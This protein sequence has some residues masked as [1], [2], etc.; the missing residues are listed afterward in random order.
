MIYT[1]A[2]L[3]E[4]AI[5][6]TLYLTRVI[7]IIISNESI[8]YIMALSIQ[9]SQLVGGRPNTAEELNQGLPETNPA[10]GQSGT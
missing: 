6:M 9:E 7:S 3:I 1:K 5:I 4:S 8:V 2:K 10:S